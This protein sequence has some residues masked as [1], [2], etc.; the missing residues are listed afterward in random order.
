MGPDMTPAEV[1]EI[2]LFC[3]LYFTYVLL[4]LILLLNLL[5]A[6]M[7]NTFISVQA[8]SVR[9]QGSH[10]HSAHTESPSAHA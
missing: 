9:G 4:A 6:S 8:A 2:G 10:R 3:V 5:I 7:N 1:F